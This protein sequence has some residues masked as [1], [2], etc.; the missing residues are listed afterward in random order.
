MKIK[1]S[2]SLVSLFVFNCILGQ[3]SI[4]FASAQFNAMDANSDSVLSLQEFMDANPNM[5]QQAFSIIDL[6]K[7]TFINLEEWNNF[8]NKHS[9]PDGLKMEASSVTTLP[10]QNAQM[11]PMTMPTMPTMPTQTQLDEPAPSVVKGVNS[12]PLL[13]APRVSSTSGA[14]SVASPT[15]PTMP[16]L[17][18]P[19]VESPTVAAP[20]V[21][22]SS[23]S[24]PLLSAPKK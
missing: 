5:A 12:L 1:I 2:A 17:K 8:L 11:P 22:K 16:V 13:S 20:S 24:M 7:D 4:A 9:T 6:D 14:S 19:T 10:A 15:A 3:T 21:E 23:S 18:A